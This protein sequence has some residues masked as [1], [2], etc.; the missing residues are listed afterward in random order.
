MIESGKWGKE[1]TSRI[2]QTVRI[3]GSRGRDFYEILFSI[4][5][6]RGMG[7]LKSGDLLFFMKFPEKRMLG[8]GVGHIGIVRTEEPA[9]KRG[10]FLIHAGGLKNKGGAVKKVLLKD[11][12]DK[13]PFVGVKVTRFD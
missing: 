12:I 6:M 1:I 3:K 2:G 11:Y 5:L 7:K 9:G 10:V 13:M 8:E 4:E